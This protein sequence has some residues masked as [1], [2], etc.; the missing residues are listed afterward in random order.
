MEDAKPMRT[1]M[2][3]SNPLSKD[4]LGKPIDQMIYR[5]MIGSLLYQT[6]CRPDIMYSLCVYARFQF[7]PHESHL[8]VIKRI[9]HYLVGT[10]NQSLL[11]K[12]NQ[13]FKLVGC[14]DANYAKDIVE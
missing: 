2:H 8:K 14:C 10:A 13:D 3:A 12:K 7:D 4:E 1:P 9:L 5:G 11:Y 6:T